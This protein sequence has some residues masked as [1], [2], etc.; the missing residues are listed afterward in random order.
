M[1]IMMKWNSKKLSKIIDRMLTNIISKNE[2]I[3]FQDTANQ[4]IKRKKVS[5]KLFLTNER[6]LF[7]S[8]KLNIQSEFT[9]INPSDITSIEKIKMM[10][11]FDNGLKVT[12]KDATSYTF[13]VNERKTWIEKLSPYSKAA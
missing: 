7:V 13:V 12:L 6:L 3:S 11:F 9:S 4:I 8:H 2:K 10:M 5:G 1:P